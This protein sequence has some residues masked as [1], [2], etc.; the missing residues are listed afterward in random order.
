MSR[1]YIS[2]CCAVAEAA[3]LA[4]VNVVA[5]YP[6]TPQTSIVEYLANYVAKGE[7]KAEMI[8]VESEHSAMSAC[9]GAACVGARTFTASSSQGLALMHEC[10]F[11]AAGLR[12][13]IVMAIANRALAAPVSIFCD[14]Q[15][16]LAQRDTGW[17]QFYVENCQEALDTILIAYRTIEDERVLLPAM[18]CLDGFFLSHISEPVD[19]PEAEQVKRF[20]P[21]HSPK[22]PILDVNN[23]GIFNVMAFPDTYE[24]FSY[25]RHVSMLRAREVLRESMADFARLFG[26]SYDLIETYG[27]EDAELI[28]LG[29]GSMMGTVRTAVRLLRE[30]GEKVGLV[31]IK[32]YRPFPTQ[33]VAA[34]VQKTAVI[35]V[36][37][38]GLS[39]GL[40]GIIY[41]EVLKSLYH[42]TTRPLAL[43]FIVGLGGR[44]VT[45][46]I[47]Q[48]AVQEMK[49]AIGASRP[50]RETIW[51]GADRA[52]LQAWGIKD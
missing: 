22:Y 16:S 21:A 2:G 27:C 30:E 25:D 50:K 45:I 8:P 17:L 29:M 19:V 1:Q 32:S 41:P 34:A 26:R 31:K 38:R 7:L 43:N 33:E 49:Q 23:P 36:L 37:D 6:I 18:V 44:D 12:L 5:A 24:E 13:P 48:R 11:M 47:L 28:L 39:T 46:P 14:H 52:L 9:I 51:P 15:D 42:L 10:L 4:E 40:G 20:L 35:G 3:R